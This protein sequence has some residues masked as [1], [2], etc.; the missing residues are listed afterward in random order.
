MGRAEGM[1]DYDPEARLRE[2]EDR[3]RRDLEDLKERR[4]SE[5]HEIKEFQ[6]RIPEEGYASRGDDDLV[7]RIPR[8]E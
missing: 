7:Q 6:D 3:V 8:I 2:E 5:E 4:K 1:D